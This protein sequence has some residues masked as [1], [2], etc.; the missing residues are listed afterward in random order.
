M[1]KSGTGTR[2]DQQYSYNMSQS[3]SHHHILGM[4]DFSPHSAA[5]S[6]PKRSCP[7]ILPI[8]GQFVLFTDTPHPFPPPTHTPLIIPILLTVQQTPSINI[9]DI[10]HF[11]IKSLLISI[12]DRFHFCIKSLLISIQYIVHFS[13]KSLRICIQD[14]FH[15]SIKSLLTNIFSIKSLLIIIQDIFHFSIKSLLISIQDILHFSIKSLLISIQDIL[16]FSIKSL[17][18]SIQYNIIPLLY[19]IIYLYSLLDQITL[20]QYSEY[21]H[22]LHQITW[23]PSH[24]ISITYTTSYSVMVPP[25]PSTPPTSQYL[26]SHLVPHSVASFSVR[27]SSCLN[28]K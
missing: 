9:H 3:F 8:L 4:S 28:D 27:I 17:R 13:I 16:H 23:Y 5:C 12:Q 20:Y 6:C 22:L 7:K 19:Q 15:F 14:I 11:S 21:I 10:F 18:I 24:H 2:L 26:T 25:S 1:T